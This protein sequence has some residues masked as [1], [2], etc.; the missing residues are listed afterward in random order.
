M[1]HR[2]PLIVS[3]KIIEYSPNITKLLIQS[4]EADYCIVTTEEWPGDQRSN[5][6]ENQL[7]DLDFVRN[8]HY[9]IFVEKKGKKLFGGSDCEV[10]DIYFAIRFTGAKIDEVAHKFKFKGDLDNGNIKATFNKFCQK[11]FIMF[12]AR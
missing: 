8:K 11:E 1:E 12:D 9:F 3:D 4:F 7:K 6:I 2:Q 5:V 10:Y